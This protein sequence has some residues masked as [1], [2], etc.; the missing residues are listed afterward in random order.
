MVITANAFRFTNP[1]YVNLSIERQTLWINRNMT[2]ICFTALA[3]VLEGS[4]IRIM[5]A[6][7][8][9]DDGFSPL[10][11]YIIL[12]IGMYNYKMFGIY[13]QTIY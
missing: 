5:C 2:Y 13:L 11:I 1:R 6:C 4:T 9:L 7:A 12:F 3:D 8:K 10:Q